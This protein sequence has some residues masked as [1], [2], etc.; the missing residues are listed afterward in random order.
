MLRAV[1]TY[2]MTHMDNIRLV[3]L[4]KDS[5]MTRYMKKTIQYKGTIVHLDK[6]KKATLN[7]YTTGDDKGP[8]TP[9]IESIYSVLQSVK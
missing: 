5:E 4:D 6:N 7:I 9:T 2:N 1:N 3:N 8:T